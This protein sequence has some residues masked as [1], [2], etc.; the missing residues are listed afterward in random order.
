[1]EH[2]HVVADPAHLLGIVPRDVQDAALQRRHDT[3]VRRA[4]DVHGA[5]IR[6]STDL[7]AARRRDPPCCVP[8]LVADLSYASPASA[9]PPSRTPIETGEGHEQPAYPLCRRPLALSPHRRDPGLVVPV[10]P[11]LGICICVL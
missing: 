3:H 5:L 4:G 1:M 10:A 9:S 8:S 2:S 6:A 7:V 11:V